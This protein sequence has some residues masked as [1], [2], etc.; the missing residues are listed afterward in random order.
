MHR[1]WPRK[2]I[3]KGDIMDKYITTAFPPTILETDSEFCISIYMPTHRTA[4]D[5]R[6]DLIRFKNIVNKIDAMDKYDK[7]VKI[8]REIQADSQFWIYNLD[9]L[10]ILMDQDDVNIYRLPRS[11][12]ERVVVGKRFYLKPLIRN[13]QSD[14]RY[15]A[16]ALSKDS[17]R[18]FT[19][20]RYGFKEIE[21][22]EEES[23]L[24]NVLGKVH[25]GRSLN[26]V[27]QGG[28]YGNFHGHGARSEEVKVDTKRF[29]NHADNYIS[30]NFSLKDK[31]PL[32]LIGLPENQA[33]FRD[34]SQND[35]LLD[36]G[37]DRSI[38]G[39]KAEEL[40]GFVWKVLEPVYIEKTNKL[41][42][43]YH[44]GLNND[45]ST[46]TL[47]DILKAIIQERVQIL[48]IEDGKTIPGVIDLKKVDYKITD[49][50]EDILNEMAQLALARNMEVVILPKER[51]P[52]H[53]SAFA[54][55][56]Y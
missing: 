33:T 56:R 21:L 25:E 4:P 28:A 23:I 19:G 8:L 10:I 35:Y 17:F 54:I 20:N 50:G 18:L 5:N 53:H 6:Q 13:F 44:E 37:I 15:H 47:H 14:D 34:N 52:K 1:P 49:D 24:D 41:V 7:Q 31:I 3:R 26:V 46:H 36:K 30:E 48:V 29:F 40:N 12:D 27:S 39:I 16:L 38:E 2:T 45:T 9:G 11:V 32:I 43:R 55:Y 42:K 51:M 22:D